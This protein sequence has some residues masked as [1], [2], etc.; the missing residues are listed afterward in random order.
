MDRPT[1][2]RPRT[3]PVV[4]DV[5]LQNKREEEWLGV[6]LDGLHLQHHA[7]L[8]RL[9]QEMGHVV[10]QRHNL[11]IQR[12][13]TPQS[14]LEHVMDEIQTFKKDR[15][16]FQKT[17]C[18]L[19][20]STELVGIYSPSSLG[21]HDRFKQGYS[22]MSSQ[23]T[24]EGA[25]P[26]LDISDR[27]PSETSLKSLETWEKPTVRKPRATSALQRKSKS[28]MDLLTYKEL[29]GI[30]RLDNISIRET[31]RQKQQGLLERKRLNKSTDIVL[32]Q[33]IDNFLKKF[34]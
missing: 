6:K 10:Q 28:N 2:P 14:T 33:K 11:L 15:R 27:N 1:K 9:N 7:G 25:F 19:P 22:K 5:Y 26:S 17:K 3:A 29:G 21:P 8:L 20:M 16:C 24:M 31:E 18:N 30:A 32:Q 4:S 12:A 34:E 13:V 23:T